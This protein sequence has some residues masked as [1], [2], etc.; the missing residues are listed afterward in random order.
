VYKLPAY[1]AGTPTREKF[2]HNILEI[3]ALV[4]E[5]TTYYA[6]PIY[7][8]GTLVYYAGVPV[9]LC[10]NSIIIYWSSSIF[11]LEYFS[12]FEQCICS[13]LFLHKKWLNFD[14]F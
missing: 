8:T 7:Y 12:D 5:L 1:Y 3:R 6:G 4:Y 2:Q 14:Y 9:Y 13:N 11:M 10:W